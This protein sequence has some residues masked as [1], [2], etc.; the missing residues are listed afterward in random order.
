G[1]AV[2]DR[3]HRPV[4][5]NHSIAA[6]LGLEPEADVLQIRQALD[7]LRPALEPCMLNGQELLRNKQISIER[8][9]GTRLDVIVTLTALSFESGNHAGWVALITE[10]DEYQEL[11]RF[12][13]QARRAQSLML[14]SAASALDQLQGHAQQMPL[15]PVAVLD[16]K[17]TA[18]KPPA[19]LAQCLSSLL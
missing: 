8:L 19:S 5:G 7:R 10:R 14:F 1:L 16:Q 6:L 17:L 13:S 4:F 3:H 2:F 12:F 11:E 9:N 15:Q 18:G